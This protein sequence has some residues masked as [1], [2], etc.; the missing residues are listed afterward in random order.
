MFSRL[1]LAV[2][3]CYLIFLPKKIENII[4]FFAVFKEMTL[5]KQP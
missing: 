3:A 4:L 1:L 5:L 2:I